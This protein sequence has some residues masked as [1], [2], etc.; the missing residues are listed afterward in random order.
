VVTEFRIGNQGQ[1][2]PD[3]QVPADACCFDFTGDG[4]V[5]NKFGQLERAAAQLVATDVNMLYAEAIASGALL[6][7]VTVEGLDD[8]E[9]DDDVRV[10]LLE[11]RDADGD[12]SNNAAGVGAFEA[13]ASSFGEAGRA[14]SRFPEASVT[15]GQL[16]AKPSTVRV[17]LPIVMGTTLD[18]PLVEARLEGPV[19]LGPDG[20]G[21]AIGGAAGEGAKLG[22]VIRRRD[23]AEALNAAIR[24]CGCLE[25]DAGK[26]AIRVTN[27]SGLKCE[28]PQ[29]DTC[30]EQDGAF[31]D[32]IGSFCALTLSMY[33]ADVDLDGDGS[34]SSVEDGISFGARLT[35]T[36]ATVSGIEGCP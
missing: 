5:D 32:G 25:F 10:S 29:I 34:K 27:T 8:L 21:L 35:T 36:S 23:L 2:A 26:D 7:L 17:S 22:G 33:A 31:C 3:T 16:V 9:N 28:A 14:V 12:P 18:V 15:S 24:K 4:Q 11:G 30:T 6:R 13:R 20:K 1:P 19:L